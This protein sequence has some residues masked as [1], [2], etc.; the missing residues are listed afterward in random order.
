MHKTIPLVICLGLAWTC[1]SWASHHTNLGDLPEGQDT[2]RVAA[3]ST[4]VV[5]VAIDQ[6]KP[7]GLAPEPGS[8]LGSATSGVEGILKS[9]SPLPARGSMY[10]DVEMPYDTQGSPREAVA[11]I[12]FDPESPRYYAME[13]FDVGSP[14]IYR[15]DLFVEEFREERGPKNPNGLHWDNFNPF[16]GNDE[17]NG[18]GFVG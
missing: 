4:L 18:D 11:P 1:S 10:V 7:I 6:S 13:P 17:G 3:H 9:E 15:S 2:Q 12:S 14:D 8:K 16:L 5:P